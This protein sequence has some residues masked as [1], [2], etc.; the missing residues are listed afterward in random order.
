MPSYF[1]P[2]ITYTS[3][4]THMSIFS[5]VSA[6][7]MCCSSCRLSL[8]IRPLLFCKTI[9]KHKCRQKLDRFRY[10]STFSAFHHS[11]IP[12]SQFPATWRKTTI[13]RPETTKIIRKTKKAL[14]QYLVPKPF[15]SYNICFYTSSFISP[16][17]MIPFFLM[18]SETSSAITAG[19]TTCITRI[20]ASTT[21]GATPFAT[22]S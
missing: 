18:I 12:E 2:L 14:K 17:L 21:P 20:S 13:K 9:I 22:I 6:K 7:Q 10:F 5:S 1:P 19:S 15:Y 16:S 11:I 8:N 3:Y 4:R